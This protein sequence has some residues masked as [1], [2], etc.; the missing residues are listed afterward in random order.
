MK[1][2]ATASNYDVS[3][4]PTAASIAELFELLLNSYDSQVASCAEV[5]GIAW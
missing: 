2:G 5:S 3:L 4:L 1:A